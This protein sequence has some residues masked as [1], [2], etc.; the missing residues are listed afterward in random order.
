MKISNKQ[1]KLEQKITNINEL[2]S[3]IKFERK[4]KTV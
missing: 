1:Y 4:K 2:K 3:T